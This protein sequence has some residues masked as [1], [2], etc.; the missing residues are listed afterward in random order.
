MQCPKCYSDNIKK[1]AKEK[2]ICRSCF[3][4]FKVD[5]KKEQKKS[6]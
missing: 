3:K 6:A 5:K 1:L 2:F 4:T